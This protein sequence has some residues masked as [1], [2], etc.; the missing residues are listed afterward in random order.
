MNLSTKAN[1]EAL[2]QRYLSGDETATKKMEGRL[3]RAVKRENEYY[4]LHKLRSRESS[5][6][7]N[8]DYAVIDTY[9]NSIYAY[10]DL[11]GLFKEWIIKDD[12]C[13]KEL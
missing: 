5:F 3:R 8:S 11:D 7:Y 12:N 4:T 10:G 9:A 1:N 6:L 2:L 13:G